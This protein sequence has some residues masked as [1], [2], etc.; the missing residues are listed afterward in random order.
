ME[1][2]N[3]MSLNRIGKRGHSLVCEPSGL[4]PAPRLG[5]AVGREPGRVPGGRSGFPSM[6]TSGKRQGWTRCR[7]EALGP[8]HSVALMVSGKD[9]QTH[10]WNVKG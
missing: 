9:R 10:F 4:V 8:C 7:E 3:M 5:C 6:G 2:T 1:A